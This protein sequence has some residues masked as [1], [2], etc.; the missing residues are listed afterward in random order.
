MGALAAD[1]R[2][3]AA[4]HALVGCCTFLVDPTMNLVAACYPY[5]G[6]RSCASVGGYHGLVGC[7]PASSDPGMDHDL[8]DCYPASLVLGRV[9]RT[10]VVC[11]SS[12]VH[13]CGASVADAAFVVVADHADLAYRAKSLAHDY[14]QND[15]HPQRRA[16]LADC[17]PHPAADQPPHEAPCPTTNASLRECC[18]ACFVPNWRLVGIEVAPP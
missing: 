2:D 6:Y 8:V 5:P 11:C 16:Q 4:F 18:L 10:A 14:I 3:L 1:H 17:D 7:Y 9:Q 13:C 12:P 15:H